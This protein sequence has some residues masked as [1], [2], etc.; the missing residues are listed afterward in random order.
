MPSGAEKTIWSLFGLFDLA[1]PYLWLISRH[2]QAQPAAED[3]DKA[4]HCWDHLEWW[5]ARRRKLHTNMPRL[6][7]FGH[8]FGTPPPLFSCRL[9]S[10][11]SWF[12][13]LSTASA[14]QTNSSCSKKPG[15]YK[16]RCEGSQIR[17]L[18]KSTRSPRASSVLGLMARA[19]TIPFLFA[20]DIKEHRSN[21]HFN[22]YNI[23]QHI[24]CFRF[25][26]LM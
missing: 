7:F 18:W 9:G 20:L 12:Q 23:T 1:Q 14:I 3:Q 15:S 2:K 24:C 21:L 6:P 8:F 22:L 19:E 10:S 25:F 13:A 11:S 17:K 5:P 4:Y 16:N 26:H